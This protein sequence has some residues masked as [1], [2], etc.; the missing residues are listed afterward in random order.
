MQQQE[1]HNGSWQHQQYNGTEMGLAWMTTRSCKQR[2]SNPCTGLER[3]WGFHE[4]EAPRFNDSQHMKV[5]RLSALCTFTPKKYFWYS[6]S[7]RMSRPQG[8]SAD[9]RIISMEN[10]NYTLGNGTHSLPVCSTV[11]QPT[12]PRCAPH[13]SVNSINKMGNLYIT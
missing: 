6:F 7:W 8:N 2:Q 10:S 12:A 13:E 1:L 11:P 3:P 9:G 4:D 5:V